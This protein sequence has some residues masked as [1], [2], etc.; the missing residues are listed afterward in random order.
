MNSLLQQFFMIPKLRYGILAAKDNQLDKKEALVFQLQSLFAH[1]SASEKQVSDTSNFVHTYKDENGQPINPR[2]QQDAQEFFNVLCDRVEKTLKGSPHAGLMQHV[3]GGKLVNQVI[4]HGGC[5]KDRERDEDF[6]C[7]SLQVQNLPTMKESLESYVLG[8][9]L[10]D[11][12][13]DACGKKTEI[14][15][16]AVIGKL[17]RTM[18]FHLKRFEL[19]W[20]TFQHEKLNNRFEF[21]MEIDLEPYT[22]EGVHRKEMADRAGRGEELTVPAQYSVH[23]KEYYQYKLFGILVHSG[24]ASAGHYFSYIKERKFVSDSEIDAGDGRWFEFNDNTVKPFDLNLVDENCFGGTETTEKWGNTEISNEKIRNAYM[25][26]YERIAQPNELKNDQDESGVPKDYYR[27]PITEAIQPEIIDVIR[28]ENTQF[29]C[30]R[31]VFNPIYFNFVKEFLRS[32]P[33]TPNSSYS[34]VVQQLPADSL[35]DCDTSFASLQLVTNFCLDSLIRSTDNKY[36]QDFV[37][38]LQPRFQ[39]HVPAACWLLDYFA[40]R[41]ALVGEILLTARDSVV[42]KGVIDLI[43]AAVAAVAP[44]ERASYGS[45]GEEGNYIF[46]YLSVHLGFFNDL[47]KNWVR[48]YEYFLFLENFSSFGPVECR[49]LHSLGLLSRLPDF[50]LG[51]ASPLWDKKT[52]RPQLG[53]V[54]APPDWS[55]AIRLV[56]KLVQSA[57]SENSLFQLTETEI[58]LLSHPILFRSFLQLGQSVDSC[59]RLALHWANENLKFSE[60]LIEGILTGL[61]K[62]D[63]A[64][65]QPFF[66]FI[67][68]IVTLNDSIRDQRWQ[69][70]NAPHKGILYLLSSNRHSAAR[71]TYLGI[72]SLISIINLN[73][74]FGVFLMKF[75]SDWAWM[76]QWLNDYITKRSYG[77]QANKQTAHQRQQ[78]RTETF[79]EIL[80]DRRKTWRKNRTKPKTIASRSESAGTIDQ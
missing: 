43:S 62:T 4:C 30:D 6:Y 18:I 49:F 51:E 15:K 10:S 40:T 70:L 73:N 24:S 31:Q 17:S 74:E 42:R 16:R 63:S 36:F 23:P 55:S 44:F 71:F 29:Y 46:R 77:V 47:P 57:K 78:S 14:T 64:G 69:F 3:F 22:K 37:S 52:R 32:S 79:Q 33:F 8:E 28:S 59:V 27:R 66:D 5:T 13:C 61:S 1:L 75:R 21:P 67:S 60:S 39:S 38:I 19:N 35:T 34:T 65:A 9:K 76:D 53:S 20:Q 41:P 72:K 7:V 26:V 48:F 54:V 80:C 45:P 68:A 2:I 58:L 25:L 56:D 11:F 50:F 12:N